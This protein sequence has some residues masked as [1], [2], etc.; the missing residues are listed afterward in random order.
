MRFPGAEQ[1]FAAQAQLVDLFETA[2]R[3]KEP[4]FERT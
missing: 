3:H 4:F 2:L 1:R